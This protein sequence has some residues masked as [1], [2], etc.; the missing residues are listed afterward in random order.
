[1]SS[2][3]PEDPYGKKI[4]WVSKKGMLPGPKVQDLSKKF[5][6]I[7]HTRRKK[8]SATSTRREALAKDA[9][10]MDQGGE[11]QLMQGGCFVSEQKLSSPSSGP[12]FCGP[13]SSGSVGRLVPQRS[14]TGTLSWEM[15]KK[16]RAPQRCKYMATCRIFAVVASVKV[17]S[18]GARAVGPRR[19]VRGARSFSPSSL[20]LLPSRRFSNLFPFTRNYLSLAQDGVPS[21]NLH[22][23]S[24]SPPQLPRPMTRSETFFFLRQVVSADI[25]LPRLHELGLGRRFPNSHLRHLHQGPRHDGVHRSSRGGNFLRAPARRTGLPATRVAPGSRSRWALVSIGCTRGMVWERGG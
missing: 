16:L 9:V 18:I 3:T 19:V 5:N 1:M 25:P 14:D 24:H 17:M 6:W 8:S 13:S 7:V 15:G 22:V 20:R 23:R 4:I 2:T 12:C 21:P 10:P 11:R